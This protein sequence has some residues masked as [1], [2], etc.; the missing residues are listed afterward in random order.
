MSLGT[1]FARTRIGCVEEGLVLDQV[2]QLSIH[3]RSVTVHH[4]F[5]A[6][7]TTQAHH[8]PKIPQVDAISPSGFQDHFWGLEK[9][10][11]NGVRV[12][13]RHVSR[14]TQAE[15][16][17]FRWPRRTFQIAEILTSIYG[18]AADKF[19]RRWFFVLLRNKFF[20][21]RMAFYSD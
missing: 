12:R 5:S 4:A 3:V 11:L 9:V 19:A 1:V 14:Y 2:P 10:G 18:P 8:D 7:L 16:C 15:V 17:D 21:G 13:T 6:N 20:N